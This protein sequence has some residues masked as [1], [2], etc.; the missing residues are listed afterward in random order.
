MATLPG[1]WRYSVSAGSVV[2]PVSVYCDWVR[3]KVWSAASISVWQQVKLSE[4]IRP[5]DTLAN[6]WEVTQST[7]QP[8]NKQTNAPCVYVSCSTLS[9]SLS[10]RRLSSTAGCSCQS[11]PYIV[12]CLMLSCS[13]WFPLSLRCHPSTSCCWDVKQPSNKQTNALC[14]SCSTL[15]NFT[16]TQSSLIHC[17]M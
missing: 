2:G 4:Q 6:C 5:W 16:F 7:K 15:F 14:M 8:A 3:W 1:V 17:R 13:R 12:V 11:K 9:I 10:L